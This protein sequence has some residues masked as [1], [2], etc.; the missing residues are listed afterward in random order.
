M[1]NM[2]CQVDEIQL[3]T[4]RTDVHL[5]GLTKPS[6]HY[7]MI[8]TRQILLAIFGLLL[9]SYAGAQSTNITFVVKDQNTGFAVPGAPVQVTAPNGGTSTLTAAANGKLV[10]VA[11]NGKYNFLITASGFKP[12]ETFF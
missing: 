3:I 10:Y 2:T 8:K 5:T 1:N 6:K 12:I 4:Q 11:V 9:A 7:A